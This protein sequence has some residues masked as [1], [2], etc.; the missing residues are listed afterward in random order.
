MLLI[1]LAAVV[2]AAAL[3]W[4]AMAILQTWRTVK[5]VAGDV[6]A[7]GERMAIA[8]DSLSTALDTADTSAHRPA[9]TA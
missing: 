1:A 4:L 2:V 7:A 5:V 8:S 6:A 9:E 3:V